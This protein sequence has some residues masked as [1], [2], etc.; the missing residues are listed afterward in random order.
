M[1]GEKVD[2]STPENPPTREFLERRLRSAR[3]N[4]QAKWLELQTAD[5]ELRI[6]ESLINLTG[7]PR[8]VKRSEDKLKAQSR[9]SRD[10]F[11][12]VV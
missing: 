3:R 5:E 7:R 8:N 11:M 4:R 1:R 6:V 10:A 12:Y 2:T 9:R